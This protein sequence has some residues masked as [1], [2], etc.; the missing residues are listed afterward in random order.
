MANEEL[1]LN[2]LGMDTISG[3]T[4]PVTSSVTQT[5]T[6]GIDNIFSAIDE[7]AKKRGVTIKPEDFQRIVNSHPEILDLPPNEQ[8]V[9]L[10]QLLANSRE[11]SDTAPKSD[12]S[13][14]STGFQLSEEDKQMLIQTLELSELNVPS[15][16]PQKL[17]GEAAD[18]DEIEQMPVE[19]NNNQE[20]LL[21]KMGNSNLEKRSEY[22]ETIEEGNVG[23]LYDMNK[24]SKLSYEEQ[25][26]EYKREY[27][28]NRFLSDSKEKYTA[29][30]WVRRLI[31]LP[32]FA[33]RTTLS[34]I[35]GAPKFAALYSSKD[36]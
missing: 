17:T 22:V 14:V 27:A 28:K 18:L 36:D 24:F 9:E 32:F 23:S 20:L 5:S 21:K 35:W 7:F 4:A 29:E 16:E 33:M 1:K 13:K 31:L 12:D 15:I 11:P 34:L 6:T 3:T 30:D 26:A 10:V 2:R 8:A 19:T 25:V